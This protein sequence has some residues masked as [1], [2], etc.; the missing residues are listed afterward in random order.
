MPGRRRTGF[1]AAL[2]LLCAVFIALACWQV[3]RRAWK[4]ALIARVDARVHAA[5][6]P[7][8]P[9]AGWPQGNAANDEYRHVRL[10]GRWLPGHAT[11]VQAVTIRGAG[12]W[13]LEP[14]QLDGGGVVL[15]N[16]G[17]VPPDWQPPSPSSSAPD[18]STASAT[19]TGLLRMDEPGGGFLRHNDPAAGRWYSRDVAAIATAQKLAGVAPFFVDADAA[20]DAAA[21]APVGGLTVVSFHDSHLVYALTWLGMALLAAWAAWWVWREGQNTRSAHVRSAHSSPG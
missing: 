17:F 4:H 1:A 20:A 18:T 8:P 11:R 14:L 9:V 3:E 21:D 5:P 12:Y 2:L 6:L 19:V 16:R 10:Q 15:V 13:L 7:P